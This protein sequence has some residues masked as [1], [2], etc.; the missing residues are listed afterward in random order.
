MQRKISTRT[1][2]NQNFQPSF[3]QRFWEKVKKTSKC[4]IWT[5]A[6]DGFGYGI[7]AIG[8]GLKLNI[9][10][11]RAVWFLTNGYIPIGMC[12]LH[13]CDNPPCVNPNHLFIGSN[14]DNVL[15]A[16]KKGRHHYAPIGNL[17][18][19]KLDHESAKTIQKLYD[20]G[21][22]THGGLSQ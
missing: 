15:D 6:K 9:R 4:W 8:G 3:E 5:G 14:R 18:A 19:K 16:V 13:H 21:G 2:G 17:Y 11:H 22:F 12:V 10:T 1:I 7:I 20:S